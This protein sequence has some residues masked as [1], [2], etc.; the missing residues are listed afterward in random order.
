MIIHKHFS[1]VTELKTHNSFVVIVLILNLNS[2]VSHSKNFIV[3]SDA[4]ENSL[5]Y[6]ILLYVLV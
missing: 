6:S 3:T 4:G 1:V 2:L 5:T